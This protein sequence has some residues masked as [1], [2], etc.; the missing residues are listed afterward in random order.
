MVYAKNWNPHKILVND[1]FQK[2]TQ[3]KRYKQV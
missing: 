3:I 2:S 1:D